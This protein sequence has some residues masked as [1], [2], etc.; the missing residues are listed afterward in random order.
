VLLQRVKMS[1][2]NS[3]QLQRQSPAIMQST[4]RP[5]YSPS[6][7]PYFCPKKRNKIFY[8]RLIQ[9]VDRQ[10][11]GCCC[12]LTSRDMIVSRSLQVE[13]VY[14]TCINYY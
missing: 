5:N 11:L 3:L 2:N 12:L 4:P 14:H 8:V 1:S 7:F 9:N 6:G 10:M 13:K